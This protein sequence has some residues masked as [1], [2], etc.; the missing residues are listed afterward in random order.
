MIYIFKYTYLLTYSL[1]RVFGSSLIGKIKLAILKVEWAKRNSN[2]KTTPV[3]YFPIDL[4]KVGD[5]SYGP[6][7]IYT[8]YTQGENLE[9]GKYCSIAKDVKFVLGGNHRS[10]CLL[11]YPFQNIFINEILN[12]S[13]TKGKIIIGN[14]VW[15]GIGSIILSG[16]EIGQGSII[17]AGSVVTKSFPR[18]SI[19][20]GNPAKILKMRFDENIIF[21]LENSGFNLNTIHPNTFIQHIDLINTPLSEELVKKLNLL[22]NTESI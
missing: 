17:A 5:F 22:N 10:D 2:N 6:I 9:I 13:L 14:D 21:L 18:Y 4:V 1:I 8:Y 11:T 20:G 19:I 3:K 16:V 15:I 7:D 12:E